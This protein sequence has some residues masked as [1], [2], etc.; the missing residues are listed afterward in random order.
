LPC[1]IV[2]PASRRRFM[3]SGK[4]DREKF[5]PQKTSIIA[6]NHLKH[7]EWMI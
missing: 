4:R 5:V 6:L 1:F 7:L 3:L 2:T